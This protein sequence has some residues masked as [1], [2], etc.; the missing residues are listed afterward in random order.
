MDCK[1]SLNVLYT[2]VDD[3]I[4]DGVD[5]DGVVDDGDGVVEEDDDDDDDV[6]LL[7]LI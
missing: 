1:Y 2:G 4:V 6:L 7:V 3:G 5:G